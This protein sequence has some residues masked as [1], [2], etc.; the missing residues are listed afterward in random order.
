M[1]FSEASG[2]SLREEKWAPLLVQVI[3]SAW[4]RV[5]SARTAWCFGSAPGGKADNTVERSKR[6]LP[7]SLFRKKGES[8]TTVLCDSTLQPWASLGENFL[9]DSGTRNSGLKINLELLFSSVAQSC[10]TLWAY[11]LQHSGLP[12]PSPIP[13]VYSNSC[14]LSW[15]CHPTISSSVIPFSSCL[16]SFPASGSF[17]MSRFF[18]SGGQSIGVSASTSALPMNIQDW[19]PLG[20]TGW[21]P[22]QSKELSR[23]FSNTTVQKHQFFGIVHWDIVVRWDKLQGKYLLFWCKI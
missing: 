17:Q 19:F 9:V 8:T 5:V 2:W 6:L 13:G 23:V 15:W 4:K 18:T 1:L 14:P 22:L 16:Q 3:A 12:C 20:W 7:E 21:I 11:G 10:P